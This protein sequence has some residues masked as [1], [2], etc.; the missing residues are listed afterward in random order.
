VLYFKKLFPGARIEA[1]EPDEGNFKLLKLNVAQN[2]FKDVILN[3]AA[4]WTTDG[5]I[6]FDANE[7]EASH[8][9]EGSTS[10][11]VSSISLNGRLEKFD[12]I[13]FLKI[14]IEGA[15]MRVIE[16]CR[17]NLIRVKNMFLEYHGKVEDTARLTE[18]LALLHESG[19][20]VYIRNA[21]DLLQHPFIEK[22]SGSLYDV[23]LNLFCYKE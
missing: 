19:F 15:E 13:D 21:A 7:T 2:N 3:Q 22:R 11:K 5:E 20:K 8:I 16:D 18:I 17:A 14:D 6:S 23:Q 1:Y 12:S 4:V 10:V 9:S